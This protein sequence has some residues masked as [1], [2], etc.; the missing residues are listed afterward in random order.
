ML[1]EQ[2]VNLID[3]V[4]SMEFMFFFANI[5]CVSTSGCHRTRHILQRKKP[6]IK[7]TLFF[8]FYNFKLKL[9]LILVGYIN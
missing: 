1:F 8:F 7:G 2:A 3:R 4:L 6:T 9:K 5:A